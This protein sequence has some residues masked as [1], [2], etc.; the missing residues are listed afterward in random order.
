MKH[1]TPTAL[2][3]GLPPELSPPDP[4]NDVRSKPPQPPRRSWIGWLVVLAL[5]AAGYWQWP[6][7]KPLLPGG[8]TTSQGTAKGGGRGRGAG[9]GTSQVVAA[10][11]TKGNIK[12]YVTGL[13]AVTP[14]YTV[15]VKSRVDGEL[16]KIQFKEGQ[17]VNKGDLLVEIDPRPGA[18]QECP[19]GPGSIQD[20][21]GPGRHSTAT[22]Q[23]AGSAGDAV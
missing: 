1:A 15:T 10:R 8:E 17:I 11:A 13:G 16:M 9:G 22:T 7:I 5:A 23:H 6:K 4:N 14:I 12:V 18:P 3:T 20:A 2:E 19:S 21:D